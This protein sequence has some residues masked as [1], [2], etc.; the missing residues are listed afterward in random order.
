MPRLS[1]R[2]SLPEAK[3]IRETPTRVGRQL[4]HERIL[5]L[6]IS[7]WGVRRQKIDHSDRLKALKATMPT[8]TPT[9]LD[10]ISAEKMKIS[11]RLARLDTDRAAVATRL[12]DLET[13]ERVLARVGKTPSAR[14]TTSTAT[15]GAKAT[16][17][18]RGRGRPPRAAS[19]KSV[20][21]RP[22]APSL[23][24]RVLA[25]ATGRTRQELYKACPNDRPNHVGIA[26][27]RHLRAGR[28]QERDG[29]LYATAPAT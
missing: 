20:G 11:E 26:V 6:N 1:N 23:G 8:T 16:A 4:D 5:R 21:R 29:K 28:I 19:G 22:S 7:R 27:Q 12:T 2:T 18:S 15:A 17:A 25:L 14:R 24:D 10:Q 9:I 3:E 13:A